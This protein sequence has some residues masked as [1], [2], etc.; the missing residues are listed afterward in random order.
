MIMINSSNEYHNVCNVT[1]VIMYVY[2]YYMSEH[3]IRAEK[4]SDTCH[5]KMKFVLTFTKN[6]LTLVKINAITL[7]FDSDTCQIKVGIVQVSTKSAQKMSDIPLLFHAL[8]VHWYFVH[9][10]CKSHQGLLQ[11]GQSRAVK[12]PICR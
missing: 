1:Y 9:E 3:E 5:H 7:N 6:D 2:V 8:H 10:I 11:S 4:C 12:L